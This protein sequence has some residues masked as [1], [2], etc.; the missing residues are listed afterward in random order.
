M[1]EGKG[2]GIFLLFY[3]NSQPMSEFCEDSLFTLTTEFNNGALE[4]ECDIDGSQSFN[5]DSN[6]GQCQCKPN[7][8][9]RT[10]SACRVGYYGFPRCQ[11]K[12][13]Y[14]FTLK[15]LSLCMTKPTI[16]ISENKAADQL[17]GYREADQRLCFRYT[18]STIS[19]LLKS[20]ISSF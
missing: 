5:C 16:C 1:N 20:E 19:L 15:K 8:I 9:G 11:R 10:C 6:G 13:L 4:C 14:C 2:F 12:S 3:F 17:R 18:D 7:V